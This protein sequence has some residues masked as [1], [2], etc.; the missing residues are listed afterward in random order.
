MTLGPNNAVALASYGNMVG[1]ELDPKHPP[2][3]IMNAIMH[4]RLGDYDNTALWMNHISS[5]VPN[6]EE[7]RIYRGWAF[8]A[9]GNIESASVEFYS[10]NSN[11]SLYWLGVFYLGSVDTEE[12]RPD[13]AFERYKDYAA[14]FDGGKSNVNFYYGVAAIK[15]YQDT[16][17]SLV[18]LIT[19]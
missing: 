10:A 9:Q 17:Q 15:A 12:G 16:N 11:S 8:I 14:E 18:L 7:A 19:A 2:N 5:L 6:P 4:W 3:S 1:F 13:I